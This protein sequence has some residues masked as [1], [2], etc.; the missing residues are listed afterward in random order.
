MTD[1]KRPGKVVDLTR[2][3]DERLVRDRL[4]QQMK[5]NTLEG[6]L[7]RLVATIEDLMFTLGEMSVAK[8]EESN[9]QPDP[10]D[11]LGDIVNEARELFIDLTA[12]GVHSGVLDWD[13]LTQVA[14]AERR[15]RVERW[16]RGR[17][18]DGPD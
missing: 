16:Q 6:L 12:V 11:T 4:R 14:D 9:D 13:T 3:L 2:V 5:E 10:L 8:G 7:G 18:T 15:R 17:N 1:K